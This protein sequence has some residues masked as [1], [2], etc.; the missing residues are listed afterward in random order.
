MPSV[1]TIRS[2]VMLPGFTPSSV[3]LAEPDQAPA[4]WQRTTPP[5]SIDAVQL[6]L[7]LQLRPSWVGAGIAA[8]PSQAMTKSTSCRLPLAS[9][10]MLRVRRI[11]RVSAPL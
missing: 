10:Q 5:T 6:A 3:S 9:Y 7:P 1:V 8:L 2:Q 11:S 4:S